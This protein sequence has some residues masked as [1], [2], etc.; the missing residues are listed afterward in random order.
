[1]VRSGPHA[2]ESQRGLREALLNRGLKGQIEVQHI[3]GFLGIAG[4]VRNVIRNNE[5]PTLWE[6]HVRHPQQW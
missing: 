3:S 2:K 4:G 5:S 1:M 6:L